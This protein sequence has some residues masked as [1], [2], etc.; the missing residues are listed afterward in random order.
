[1]LESSW[2]VWNFTPFQDDV[3]LFYMAQ[4]AIWFVT[5][6]HCRFIEVQTYRVQSLKRRL[7]FLLYFCQIRAGDFYVMYSHHVVTI[8]LVLISLCNV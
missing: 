1:M 7:I 4:L 2:G 3:H 5:A 8:A 6:I